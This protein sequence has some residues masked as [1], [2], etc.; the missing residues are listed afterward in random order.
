MESRE[1]MLLEGK[2]IILLIFGK[3]ER[4]SS[5]DL[6]NQITESNDKSK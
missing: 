3:H 2:G 6:D 4:D 1:S 5:F